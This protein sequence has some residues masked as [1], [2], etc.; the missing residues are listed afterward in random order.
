MSRRAVPTPRRRLPVVAAGPLGVPG[1]PHPSPS[2][3]LAA[4]SRDDV[5]GPRLSPVG[6]R[7]PEG[8]GRVGF[9]GAQQVCSGGF[10]SGRRGHKQ[11]TPLF[12][13]GLSHDM[14]RHFSS[15]VHV[16]TC[17]HAR[18]PV[19]GPVFSSPLSSTVG[20]RPLTV[21]WR[22][23]GC[24]KRSGEHNVEVPLFPELA[25]LSFEHWREGARGVNVQ[26]E[27][28]LKRSEQNRELRSS[29]G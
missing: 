29:A 2:V 20:R 17:V 1:R 23:P 5:K 6:S 27:T 11:E 22:C 14:P 3:E 12:T 26:G 18:A 13:F 16:H 28:C 24:W 8:R 21:G 25:S 9:S 10:L 7:V 4:L 19:S 15:C